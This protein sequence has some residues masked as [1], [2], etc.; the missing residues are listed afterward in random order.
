MSLQEE[1]YERQ[2]VLPQIGKEGQRRL[3]NARVLIVGAGGLGCPLA[4]Y[5]NAAGIGHIGIVDAD[6]VC[7][8]NL[9]RQVL[10]APSEI[11]LNKARQAAL[12]L[13]RLNPDIDISYYK[14]RLCQ[15]NAERLI[16][17]YDIVADACD[18]Y[19]T[20][21][22]ISDVCARQS[23]PYV[24][25]AVEGFC[26]QVAVL[27][28]TKNSKT[29]RDILSADAISDRSDVVSQGIIG[30]SPAV[31]AAVE[32]SEIMKLVC[33]YGDVLDGRLWVIDLRTMHSDVLNI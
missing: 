21:F 29:Y 27:C 8:S 26:G 32:V 31:V 15:S 22:L 5:L 4:L 14:C 24:Y 25:A 12:H 1:R 17:R 9:N 2:M 7:A 6:T 13:R 33:G 18:N 11:G 28:R 16:A 10:Y 30:A 3:G 20:R 19:E 23:K